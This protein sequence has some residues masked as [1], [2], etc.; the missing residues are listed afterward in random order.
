MRPSEKITTSLK[1]EYYLYRSSSSKK[2]HLRLF[3]VL[4][5]EK[6]LGEDIQPL[7]LEVKVL[8]LKLEGVTLKQMEGIRRQCRFWLAKK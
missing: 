1:Y 3:L 2:L 5:K 6:E 8:V 7:L 4:V